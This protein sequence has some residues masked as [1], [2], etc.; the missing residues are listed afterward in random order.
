MADTFT[1]QGLEYFRLCVIR[2]AMGLYLKSGGKL[3][4]NRA[5]T[6]KNMTLAVS[7]VTGKSYKRT[8]DGLHEALRDLDQA[9]DTMRPRLQQ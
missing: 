5:Y 9:L 2:S 6:A 8:L 1:G 7:Q 4:A 3:R